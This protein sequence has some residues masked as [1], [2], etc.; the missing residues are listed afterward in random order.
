MSIGATI[1]LYF[2]TGLSMQS[3]QYDGYYLQLLLGVFGGA[4]FFLC[5][6]MLLERYLPFIEYWGKYSLVIL[7]FHNFILIPCAK[8]TGRVLHQSVVWSLGT[9]I[10]IYLCFY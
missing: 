6:S 10:I 3:N 8:I 1:Y 5:I 9:F 4:M 7:C 2:G